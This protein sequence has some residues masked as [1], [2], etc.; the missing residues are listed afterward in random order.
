[1]GHT[2]SVYSLTV[3]PDG[4]L[5]SGGGSFDWHIRIWNLTSDET[6][7]TLT[8]HTSWINSLVVL[9]DGSLVSGSNDKT[10]RVWNM[11]Y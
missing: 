7:K 11:I 10:I 4:T 2:S 8:G 5:A 6:I 3:L 9:P 1:M